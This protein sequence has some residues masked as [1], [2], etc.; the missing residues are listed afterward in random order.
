LKVVH[1]HGDDVCL[2]G[3]GGGRSKNEMGGNQGYVHYRNDFP[4]ECRYGVELI[5]GEGHV[6]VAMGWIQAKKTPHGICP[7]DL[8]CAGD[9]AASGEGAEIVVEDQESQ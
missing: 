8:V 2:T 3:V 9:L 5:G 6:E 7:K 4:H 1:V